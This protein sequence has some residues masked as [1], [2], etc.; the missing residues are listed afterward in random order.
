MIRTN[1]TIPKYN[2]SF[3][4]TMYRSLGY[5]RLLSIVSSIHV[6]IGFPAS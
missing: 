3:H 5:I 6:Q 2:P 4:N 1:S